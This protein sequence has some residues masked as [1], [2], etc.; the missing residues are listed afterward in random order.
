[1]QTR[2]HSLHSIAQRKHRC[3]PF[4]ATGTERQPTMRKSYKLP[5]AMAWLRSHMTPGQA[6]NAG[7]V[8]SAALRDG[9]AERTVQLAS[10]LLHIEKREIDYGRGRGARQWE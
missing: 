4:A 8:L 3:I 2:S 5:A 6:Y 10:N 7:E 1:M 9:H